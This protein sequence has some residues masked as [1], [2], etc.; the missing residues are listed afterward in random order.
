MAGLYIHVPFCLSRCAYCDFFSQTQLIFKDVYIQS[1][2]RELELRK[3]Y[4]EGDTIETIYW[5]GGTPSLLQPDDFNLVF[6]SINRFYETS[7]SLE[8]TLE[9]NPDDLTKQ[10]VSAL[11]QLPFNRIS[12]G[13]QSFNE[14]DLQLLK[15][16]HTAKQAINVISFCQNAG[17]SN[18]SIDLIYGL[19]GQ[20]LKMWEENLDE[21][22]RLQIP[23]LSA[24]YLTYEEGTVMHQQLQAGLIESLNEET[25]VLLFDM[26]I[27]KLDAAGYLHYEIANFCK[28]DYYS[29][30][31]T[32]CWTDRKYIGIGP[33][34]HSYNHHSRQWNIASLPDYIEGITKGA[35][36]IEKELIDERTRYNDY[37]LTRLR[38]IWGIQISVFLK[39]FGRE[40]LMFLLQQANPFLQTGL[41][42]KDE[43]NLKISRKGIL[44][45][46]GI[47]S[48]L[49]M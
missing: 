39:I 6:N 11:R 28:P 30:H 41:M 40:R 23:H 5:G 26:L 17:Y 13:V 38:T 48:G 44:L 9:A 25:G 22:I 19:P 32:A 15:R 1:V 47:I 33:A 4:L 49:M 46:D 3:D 36:N 31:N 14:K 7:A 42:K 37:I 29:R 45:T 24:Y 18:I 20:T 35:P 16:R 8:I 10:Y 21:A 43:E 2:I 34:A 12:I 27:D